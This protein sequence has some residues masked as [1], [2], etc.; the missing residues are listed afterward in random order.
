[1]GKLSLME[2]TQRAREIL[3]E[4]KNPDMARFIAN[5][6]GGAVRKVGAVMHTYAERVS[7]LDFSSKSNSD[8]YMIDYVGSLN[9]GEYASE[10]VKTRYLATN[11]SRNYNSM[12]IYLSATAG[13]FHLEVVRGFESSVYCDAF[14]DQLVKHGIAFE[15]DAET[16]YITPQNGL[17]EGLGLI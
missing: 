2:Q 10:I 8:T 6:M 5:Q 11:L 12:T 17:I 4:S 3:R 16:S 13:F 15:R 7:V 14:L 9:A 1:M